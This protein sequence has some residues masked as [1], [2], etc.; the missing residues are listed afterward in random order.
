MRG[1][2]VLREREET[3]GARIWRENDFS[4]AHT[5]LEKHIVKAR[6]R[7]LTRYVQPRTTTFR[8]N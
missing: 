8:S 4:S 1:R 6:S 7:D 5:E 3:R 2:E